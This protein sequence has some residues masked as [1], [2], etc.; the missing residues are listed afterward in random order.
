MSGRDE[1]D[2][3]CVPRVQIDSIRMI[4]SSFNVGVN[5]ESLSRSGRGQISGIVYAEIGGIPFP[6]RQWSDLIVVVLSFWLESLGTLA[7]GSSR[8]TSLR[9]MDGPFRLDVHQNGERVHL[10]AIDSRQGDT[11]VHEMDAEL[12]ALYT[13]TEAAAVQV[14]RACSEK[15]WWSPD[16]DRLVQLSNQATK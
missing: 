7:A 13:A 14:L 12:K 4:K 15:G 1:A 8:S 9:F 10:S 11:L 6:E 3:D 5:T 2:R 16:I